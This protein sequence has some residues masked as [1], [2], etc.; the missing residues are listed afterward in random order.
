MAYELVQYYRRVPSKKRSSR[1]RRSKSIRRRSRRRSPVVVYYPPLR[2]RSYRRRSASPVRRR[3]KNSPCAKYTKINCGAVD[4]NCNWTSRG[5][6]RRSG[7]KLGSVYQGPQM[8]L[9]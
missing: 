1:R 5:C 4:P 6:K 2:R 7:V 3:V 9:R 8:L